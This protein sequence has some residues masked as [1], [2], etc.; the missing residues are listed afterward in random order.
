MIEKKLHNKDKSQN[1][2]EKRLKMIYNCEFDYKRQNIVDP[3]NMKDN[4]IIFTNKERVS[5][6]CFSYACHNVNCCL[7]CGVPM[8]LCFAKTGIKYDNHGLKITVSKSKQK[9]ALKYYDNE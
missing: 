8:R 6:E 1:R 2:R 9:K 7:T 5:R 3:F 4:P